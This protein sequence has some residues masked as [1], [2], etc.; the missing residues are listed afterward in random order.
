[1]S[2]VGFGDFHAK[3]DFERLLCALILLFGVSIFSYI[4]G[5]FITILDDYNKLNEDLDDGDEL[6][7]FFGL[8]KYLNGNLQIDLTLKENIEQHF[9]YKWKNDRNQAIFND[10]D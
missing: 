7:K 1:M 4:M 8:I 3:S 10:R 5:I 2:T 6:S 9:M